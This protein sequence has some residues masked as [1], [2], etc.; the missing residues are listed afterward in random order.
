MYEFLYWSFGSYELPEVLGKI[1]YH[2]EFAYVKS[3]KFMPAPIYDTHLHAYEQ[4]MFL[5]KD[6][7]AKITLQ[8]NK[9][10]VHK[11]LQHPTLQHPN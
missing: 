3:A 6:T 2:S 4:D 8:H 11:L 1:M 10:K 9:Q 5:T 7:A